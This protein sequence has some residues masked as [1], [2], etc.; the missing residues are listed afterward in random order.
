MFMVNLDE[1]DEWEIESESEPISEKGYDF[2]FV[3][4]KRR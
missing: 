3:T 1:S 2:K 4:Y